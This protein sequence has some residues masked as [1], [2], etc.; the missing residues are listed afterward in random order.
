MLAVPGN[1]LS[2]LSL[3]VNGKNSMIYEIHAVDMNDQGDESG[4]V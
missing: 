4:F 2:L 1:I 3:N